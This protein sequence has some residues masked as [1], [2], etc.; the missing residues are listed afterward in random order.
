[1]VYTP[2]Q[3]SDHIGV[4]AVLPA[5]TKGPSCDMCTAKTTRSAQPHLAQATIMQ[6]FTLGAAARRKRSSSELQR[7]QQSS[8][9]PSSSAATA[10]V[11]SS[12]AVA[13]AS[14]PLPAPLCHQCHFR[15][16][17]CASAKGANK[18]RKKQKGELASG[19]SRYGKFKSASLY[20][21]GVW[22]VVGTV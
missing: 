20:P 21:A 13:P 12:V 22:V 19:V 7:L 6:S 11:S 15:V 9:T 16:C 2:P 3:M 10:A 5:P 1:M 14:A 18:K 17:R 4:S 8:P